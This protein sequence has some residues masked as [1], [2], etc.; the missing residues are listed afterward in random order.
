MY[1]MLRTNLSICLLS[2]NF[3]HWKENLL[4]TSKNALF[5]LDELL[6]VNGLA[7]IDQ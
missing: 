1:K 4:L 5:H 6:H 3:L 2:V 7:A